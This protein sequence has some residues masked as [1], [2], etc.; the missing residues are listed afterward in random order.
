MSIHYRQVSGFHWRPFKSGAKTDPKTCI[1]SIE[2]GKVVG[3]LMH[4]SNFFIPDN[5]D[6]PINPDTDI[7]DISTNSFDHFTSPIHFISIDNHVSASSSTRQACICIESLSV[8]PT[9]QHFSL[10][11][12]MYETRFVYQITRTISTVESETM[13]H[14]VHLVN[15]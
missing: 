14:A 13:S 15:R 10:H 5:Y 11:A 2:H 7:C 8:L 4:A 1:I 6:K 12:L 3:A 9:P